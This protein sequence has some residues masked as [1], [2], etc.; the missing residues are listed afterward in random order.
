MSLSIKTSPDNLIDTQKTWKQ[1]KNKFSP[2]NS[3]RRSSK[4]GSPRSGSMSRSRSMSGRSSRSGSMSGRSSRS[5]SPRISKEDA[6]KILSL[7]DTDQLSIIRRFILMT[8]MRKSLMAWSAWKQYIFNH[9]IWDLKQKK[10]KAT[11]DMLEIGKSHPPGQRTE[12]EIKKIKDWAKYAGPQIFKS[13]KQSQLED[14]AQAL[15]C[16]TYPSNH[17]LFLQGQKGDTFW[18]ILNGQIKIFVEDDKIYEQIKIHNHI[19]HGQEW[20]NSAVANDPTWLGRE[21]SRING[22]GFGELALFEG[23]GLRNA[24]AMTGKE[25]DVILIPKAVYL[26]TLA[27]LHRD[28]YVTKR[29]I[30]FLLQ[31]PL[32]ENWSKRRII[33]TAY[34]LTREKYTKGSILISQNTIPDALIFIVIG[35]VRL[36]RMMDSDDVDDLQNGIDTS[37]KNQKTTNNTRNRKQKDKKDE[38]VATWKNKQNNKHNQQ[39]KGSNSTKSKSKSNPNTTTTTTTTATKTSVP[40]TFEVKTHLEQNRAISTMEPVHTRRKN[41]TMELSVLGKKSIVGLM[42]PKVYKLRQTMATLATSTRNDGSVS[43]H[44][45]KEHAKLNKALNSMSTPWTA[46]ATQDTEVFILSNKHLGTFCARSKGTNM[47]EALETTYHRR[48]YSYKDRFRMAKA[49]KSYH[50]LLPPTRK[51]GAFSPLRSASSVRSTGD[52]NGSPSNREIVIS[53]PSIMRKKL[54]KKLTIS[55]KEQLKQ[56]KHNK[57]SNGHGKKISAMFGGGGNQEEDMLDTMRIRNEI[58]KKA[59]GRDSALEEKNGKFVEF[60]ADQQNRRSMALDRAL[61]A[62]LEIHLDEERRKIMMN[63]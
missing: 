25:T 23:D 27:H 62:C 57:N 12:E 56:S 52:S 14:V 44:Q 59:K 63:D 1:L 16:K 18:I 39:L 48:L 55:E 9:R 34:T 30:N 32:F 53:M 7:Y 46:I 41:P 3:S 20:I 11:K 24:S 60:G 5:N 6:L 4:H 29:K 58:Q 28:A 43:N 54:S 22:G 51:N 49:T 15:I 21:V 19:N 17:V 45:L 42:A 26:R 31:F 47:Y 40:T 10:L 2:T 13:L 33:D 36:L 37:S 61:D 35:E 50:G 38:S 8:E